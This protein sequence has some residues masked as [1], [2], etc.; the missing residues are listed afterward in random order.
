MIRFTKQNSNYHPQNIIDLLYSINDEVISGA[1]NSLTHTVIVVGDIHRS[2]FS[3][4]NADGLYWLKIRVVNENG[5]VIDGYGALHVFVCFRLSV[6]RNGS[7]HRGPCITPPPK[8]GTDIAEVSNLVGWWE[9]KRMTKNIQSA[10]I[11]SPRPPPSR[12]P[13]KRFTITDPKT[14]KIIE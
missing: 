1:L 12:R 8:A 7:Y 4:D 5:A 10:I 2:M 14:G 9:F 11:N 3:A 6:L 13:S